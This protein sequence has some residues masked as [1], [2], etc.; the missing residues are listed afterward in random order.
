MLKSQPSE[1][2]NIAAAALAEIGPG[3]KEAVPA[4][5]EAYAKAFE[6]DPKKGMVRINI[7]RAL[8]ATGAEAVPFL[9]KDKD[10]QVRDFTKN[11]FLSLDLASIQSIPVLIKLLDNKDD[12][13]VI[14]HAARLLGNIGP[15]AKAASPRLEKALNEDVPLVRFSAALALLQIETPEKDV[16]PFLI[17]SLKRKDWVVRHHSAYE[18]FRIGL[19]AQKAIPALIEL[20]KDENEKV[21][22]TAARALKR[23]QK[24]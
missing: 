17:E 24:D 12:P 13:K 8:F 10:P 4:L 16:V 7:F 3:A 6:D 22:E 9:L 2:R 5:V 15:E 20:K 23:I 21:R 19:P 18:L 14:A 1:F 11:V